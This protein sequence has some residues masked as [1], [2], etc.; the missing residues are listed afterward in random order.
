MHCLRRQNVQAILSVFDTEIVV[1]FLTRLVSKSTHSK[2]S[3]RRTA[4]FSMFSQIL[5]SS[6]RSGARS[7][8]ILALSHKVEL[9]GKHWI[10]LLQPRTAEDVER[11]PVV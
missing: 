3:D 5:R 6:P 1:L 9:S 7:P 11:F 4:N 8:I 10:P 2:C